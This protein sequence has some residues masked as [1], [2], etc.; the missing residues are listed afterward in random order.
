[1]TLKLI[2][3]FLSICFTVSIYSLPKVGD[4]VEVDQYNGTGSNPQYMGTF[5]INKIDS[6]GNYFGKWVT[7]APY[8]KLEGSKPS[9][10]VSCDKIISC[11]AEMEAEEAEFKAKQDELIN[12]LNPKEY[13]KKLFNNEFFRIDRT[14]SQGEVIEVCYWPNDNKECS[15]DTYSRNYIPAKVIQK[16]EDSYTVNAR[17]FDGTCVGNK[18]NFVDKKINISENNIRFYDSTKGA[19]TEITEEMARYE[20]VRPGTLVDTKLNGK[21]YRA[22]VLSEPGYSIVKVQYINWGN[23]TGYLGLKSPLYEFAPF[24]SKTKSDT[25]TFSG[26][27]YPKDDR[28]SSK[29]DLSN[30]KK[31]SKCP[32]SMPYVSN[33]ICV[34]Q[35]G[36]W[37]GAKP[38]RP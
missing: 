20:V 24:G 12:T 8:F 22:L 2:I 17:F 15:E 18:C 35:N 9:E 4:T 37:K 32:F 19:G 21:W 16:S 10:S 34:D 25:G 38:I 30:L 23:I 28:E 3:T 27:P 33:G 1:M 31:N 6:E 13:F 14:L 36:Q 11:K 5:K 26:M 7:P 29:I